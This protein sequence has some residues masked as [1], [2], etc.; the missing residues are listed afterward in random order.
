MSVCP[1]R[2]GSRRRVGV[3][4]EQVILVALGTH[5]TTAYTLRLLNN[6]APISSSRRAENLEWRNRSPSVHSMNST[7]ATSSGRTHTHFFIFSASKIPT[8]RVQ[9]PADSRKRHSSVSNHFSGSME[10]S[11]SSNKLGG[12]GFLQR[13]ADDQGLTPGVHPSFSRLGRRQKRLG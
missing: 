11:A 6:L 13:I 10:A 1:A 12:A 2:P 9:F 8:A 3:K 4:I 7:T 5:I